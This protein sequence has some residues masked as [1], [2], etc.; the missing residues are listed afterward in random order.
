MASSWLKPNSTVRV[1]V[2]SSPLSVPATWTSVATNVSVS[3][4]E[5]PSS[6]SIAAT[7]S[8]TAV[9]LSVNG[10]VTV[11][12]GAT[13]VAVV[14]STVSRCSQYTVPSS[15]TFRTTSTERTSTATP[16]AS[17]AVYVTRGV[18]S[19]SGATFAK[20]VSRF[21]RTVPIVNTGFGSVTSALW[22][23]SVST[24]HEET[25]RVSGSVPGSTWVV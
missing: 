8:S 9:L 16:S 7:R 5:A 23:Y 1:Y 21:S 14:E 13:P 25:V 2:V 17:S 19:N 22:T 15:P 20:Y 24:V 10:A 3:P 18:T 11:S 12:P 4:G 6:D